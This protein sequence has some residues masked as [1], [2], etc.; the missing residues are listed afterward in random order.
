MS[1]RSATDRGCWEQL[2]QLKKE[3]NYIRRSMSGPPTPEV[4][5][6]ASVEYID[7]NIDVSGPRPDRVSAAQRL[8][9]TDVL[10]PYFVPGFYHAEL[11][12]DPFS[13]S[14]PYP[15][16][17][18]LTDPDRIRKVGKLVQEDLLNAHHATEFGGYKNLYRKL[19]RFMSERRSGPDCSF[20]NEPVYVLES[21]RLPLLSRCSGCR[22]LFHEVC[23]RSSRCPHCNDFVE[24]FNLLPYEHAQAFA[25]LSEVSPRA[26]QR[27]VKKRLMVKRAAARLRKNVLCRKKNRR[28]K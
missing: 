27:F 7:R 15:E 17:G 8:G 13:P 22:R 23:S 5:P 6:A 3:L 21:G 16:T 28:L 20:C 9:N 24:G 4:S 26:A 18:P 10:W 1:T 12:V 19:Y 2:E 14:L 11:D 25:L